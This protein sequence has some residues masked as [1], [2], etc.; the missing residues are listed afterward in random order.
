MSGKL[1]GYNAGYGSL[2]QQAVAQ[3]LSDDFGNLSQSTDLTIS[4]R[5]GR[6]LLT[7][8]GGVLAVVLAAPIA[9]QDDGNR[10]E[11]ANVTSQQHTITCTGKLND[12]AGHLNI[13]TFPAHPGA[14]FEIFAYQGAW[15]LVANNLVAFT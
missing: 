2:S 13:A 8:T 6:R 1:P 14:A 3:F 10:I 9:G 15:Y 5:P 11:I 12:G 4:A 7:Y